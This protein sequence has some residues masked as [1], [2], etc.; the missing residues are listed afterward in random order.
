MTV[1]TIEWATHVWN[2]F[3]GCDVISPGCANC[4]AKLFAA[5]LNRREQGRIAKAEQEGKPRPTV[6][7]QNDGDPRSSGPGFGFTVHWDKLQR[8]NFPAGA[9]VFVNSM[10]D[11]FHEE[12]PV[13]AIAKLWAAF[14]SKPAVNFLVLTKRP[15]RMLDLLG[16]EGE[17]FTYWWRQFQP[18]D[19]KWPL[20][21]VWLGVS[22][23]NRRF[24]HRADLL[25]QTPAAVRF[26]SAEPLLGPLVHNPFHPQ[27]WPPLRL[28]QIDWLIVGGESGPG[29][30]RI[31]REWVRDL[32]LTCRGTICP[33]CAGLGR[34]CAGYGAGCPRCGDRRTETAFFFKQWGGRRAKEGGRELDGRTWDELPATRVA[35]ST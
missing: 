26:I 29:H 9:R 11:V 27:D 17:E 4:Y 22:I 6:R 19:F 31:D 33:L 28:H 21:N 5:D 16:A 25:R 32:C 2:P 3:T 23:E 7:Y 8:F 30:R 12:A 24:V 10:S 15:E 34:E 18:D 35:V 20:P 14:A 13:E 1:T